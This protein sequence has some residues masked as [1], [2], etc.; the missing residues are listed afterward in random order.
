MKLVQRAYQMAIKDLEVNWKEISGNTSNPLILECYYA[1]D[2]IKNPEMRDDSDTPWCSCYAN[3]KIQ[4]AGGRGTRSPLARSWLAWGKESEGN[5][6]DLV[7]LKRGDST[8]Q[9][10]VGFLHKK[11]LLYVE[12]LGGNQGNTVSIKKF[13]RANVLGYR[14]SKD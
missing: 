10:H 14:T 4:D 5:V 6:G 2:G 8:W 7:V 11:G 3:K 12:I 13:L 9:G 1:V